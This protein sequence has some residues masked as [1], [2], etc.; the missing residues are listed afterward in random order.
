MGE[1]EDVREKVEEAITIYTGRVIENRMTKE[2]MEAVVNTFALILE[3]GRIM[4]RTPWWKFRAR[5]IYSKAIDFLLAE[6][7]KEV[8]D[9][10]KIKSEVRE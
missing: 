10:V 9:K 8:L 3:I 6:I 5:K 2:E 4:E 1:M 7:T